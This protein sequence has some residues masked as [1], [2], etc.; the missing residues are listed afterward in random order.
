MLANRNVMASIAVKDLD[1]AR[2]FYSDTLGLQ[3]LESSDDMGVLNYQSGSA[4]A[5]V[6]VSQFAATNKAT[7]ATWAVGHE[8]DKIM[9]ALREKGVV[10]ERYDMPGMTFDNGAHVAGNFRG[11]WFKDPDG[12]ILHILNG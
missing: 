7:S 8:F 2:K 12:N 10:F 4:V 9:D 5:V 6:Y 1:T 11:A 3:L